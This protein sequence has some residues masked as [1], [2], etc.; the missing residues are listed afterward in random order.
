MEV[1]N[2][3]LSVVSRQFPVRIW[4]SLDCDQSR[5]IAQ[6]MNPLSRHSAPLFPPRGARAAIQPSYSPHPLR[7]ERMNAT[8]SPW[9]PSGRG[10]QCNSSPPCIPFGARTSVLLFPPLHP[11]RGKDIS[12]TLSP[13]ASPSGRGHQS[14]SFLPSPPW[15]RGAGGEGVVS[16][17][18]TRLIRV[19]VWAA[20]RY[21][22]CPP[23]TNR[24]TPLT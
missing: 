24:S 4:I 21:A 15:G 19:P 10:H 6:S 1:V 3:Q 9:P 23:S 13:L 16:P 18:S 20:K 7:G 11:L 17:N 12:A 8:F 5:I 2:S 14:Y 22:N